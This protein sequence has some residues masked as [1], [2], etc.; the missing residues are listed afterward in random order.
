MRKLY[1]L[2]LALMLMAGGV[3]A[4]PAQI[5]N[6]HST[7]TISNGSMKRNVIDGNY[8]RLS[9]WSGTS[10]TH[11]ADVSQEME[12]LDPITGVETP[13]GRWV[14]TTSYED[15]D[16]GDAT[17]TYIGTYSS[18]YDGAYSGLEI[19]TG[20]SRVGTVI[21]TSH[22][23]GNTQGRS[24]FFL[25]GS[26]GDQVAGTGGHRYTQNASST[27]ELSV[28]ADAWVTGSPFA[29]KASMPVPPTGIATFEDEDETFSDN[30]SDDD[31]IDYSHDSNMDST[32]DALYINPYS[33]K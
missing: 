2:S 15:T 12:V 20:T 6:T 21:G 27:H 31:D 18:E 3:Y 32:Y 33:H 29:D 7:T 10:R 5:T 4:D 19:R 25:D 30:W 9:H 17:E 8:T 13:T 28:N 24:D 22:E 26:M 23:D 14:A 16:Y 11:L 1:L